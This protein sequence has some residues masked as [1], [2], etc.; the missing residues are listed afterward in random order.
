MYR[1]S[2]FVVVYRQ[3]TR[4]VPDMNCF[5]TGNT[6]AG[7]REFTVLLVHVVAAT[8]RTALRH[9]P[10]FAIKLIQDFSRKHTNIDP[11]KLLDLS[12]R[13][14]YLEVDSRL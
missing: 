6:R 4:H 9:S 12:N 10:A 14:R 5:Y 13:F 3:L 11:A 7:V 1:L 8:P 2:A